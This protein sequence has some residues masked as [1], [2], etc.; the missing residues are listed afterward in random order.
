MI[1]A[2]SIVAGLAALLFFAAGLMKVVRPAPAL[3]ENGMGWVEDFSPTVVKLIGLAEVLGGIGL[4]V[5][6]ITGIAPILSPIAGICLVIIMIGAAMVHSRRK[7]PA[8]PAIGIT[9]L[10]AV[11]TVLAFAVVL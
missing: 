3:R 2:F 1:I 5:P 9:V 11:A 6:V 7:E 8:V 10:T 4:I